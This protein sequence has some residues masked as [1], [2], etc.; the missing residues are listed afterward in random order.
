ML[1]GEKSYE[2]DK[3][4][5]IIRFCRWTDR[6]MKKQVDQK[7]DERV[8][9]PDGSRERPAVVLAMCTSEAIKSSKCNYNNKEH[10]Q[11]FNVCSKFITPQWNHK[12]IRIN[13]VK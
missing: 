3:Q 8:W 2:T 5:I 13:V 10:R 12:W 7:L 4:T 9:Q 6:Q 11:A 1:H